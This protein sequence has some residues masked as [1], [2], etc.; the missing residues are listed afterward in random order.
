MRWLHRFAARTIKEHCNDVLRQHLQALQRL[1]T[2]NVELETDLRALEASHLSFM[3]KSVGK[4]GGRPRAVVADSEAT[5]LDS[6]AKGDKAA[7]RQ[8]FREEISRRGPANRG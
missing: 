6:I 7:L 2:K 4:L 3:R 5:D 1:E 8:F